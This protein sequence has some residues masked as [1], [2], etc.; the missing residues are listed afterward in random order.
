MFRL[1][2][3]IVRVTFERSDVCFQRCR[4][5]QG[6]CRIENKTLGIC[7]YIAG[8]LQIVLPGIAGSVPCRGFG[9]STI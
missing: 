3:E 6:G 2:M 1:E 4:L 9:V 5:E 7:L 8:N